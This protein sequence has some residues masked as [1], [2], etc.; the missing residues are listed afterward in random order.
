MRQFNPPH[1]GGFICRNYL[2]PL[3]LSI[4]QMAKALQV[5][6]STL[7]RLIKEQSSISPD[8]AVRL[9]RITG[10]SPESWLKMQMNYDLWQVRQSNDHSELQRLA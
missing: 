1:P 5:S 9:S 4:T 7:S 8:M 6:P 2:D 10:R 3:G